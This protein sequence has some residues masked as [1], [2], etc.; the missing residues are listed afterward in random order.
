MDVAKVLRTGGLAAAQFGQTVHGVAN[1]PLMKLRRKMAGLLGG[2][3]AG[4]DPTLVLV[5]SDAA[6]GNAMD[7]AFAAHTEPI[8]HW[9]S[10]VWEG[11]MPVD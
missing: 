1:Y 11:W 3:S 4:K 9:A 8:V 6:S 5:A 7:P 2:A 10:A